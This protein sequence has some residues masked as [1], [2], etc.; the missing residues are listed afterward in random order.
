MGIYLFYEYF[1][2]K[3]PYNPKSPYSS[4]KAASDHLAKAWANT[5]ELPVLVTNC[6]NN[7]GPRQF[8]EKLIPL[9]IT[10]ALK[11]KSIPIF[12]KGENIR[13]WIY[14][15]DHID[16]LFLVAERG[17]S[18]SSYCIGGG[19]EI[20]NIE[21]VESICEILNILKPTN[22]SYGELIKFV[23]DRPGQDFRYSINPSK[24]IK[25]LGWEIKYPFRTAIESTVKW[26][27]NNQD[28]CENKLI[29]SGYKN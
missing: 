3:T 25:E 16:A 23:D 6:S 14:V 26:Y 10:N 13:D 28:W 11:N 9:T 19:Q 12:G 22:S 21:L 1:D 5:Y 18:G 7:F 24:I 15:E 2:E 17:L 4:T 27:L 20:T 8:P 29:N